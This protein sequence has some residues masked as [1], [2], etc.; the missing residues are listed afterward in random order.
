MKGNKMSSLKCFNKD[1]L[2][3]ANRIAH[4][5]NYNRSLDFKFVESLPDDKWFPIVMTL[6]HEHAMGVKVPLHMRCWVVFDEKG[7]RAFIDIDMKLYKNLVEIE[8]PDKETKSTFL[9]A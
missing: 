1:S 6:P 5:K 2:I 4:K 3:E 9:D 7:H 8:V